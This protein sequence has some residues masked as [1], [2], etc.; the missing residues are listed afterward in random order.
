MNTEVGVLVTL[1][2]TRIASVEPF[3]RADQ[4]INVS[5][6]KP[7]GVEIPPAEVRCDLELEFWWEVED[8]QRGSCKPRRREWVV[9]IDVIGCPMFE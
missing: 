2:L 9:K 5:V 1:V 4:L 7:E 6:A 8:G 3:D